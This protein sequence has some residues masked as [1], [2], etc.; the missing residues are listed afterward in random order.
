M[1]FVFC[2]S[3]YRTIYKF[4]L[5]FL[6]TNTNIL[7]LQT[8]QERWQ[9]YLNF[10]RFLNQ[11]L[12]NWT[13]FS[14][15]WPPPSEAADGPGSAA[16]WCSWWIIKE[17]KNVIKSCRC[18]NTYAKYRKNWSVI[19]CNHHFLKHPGVWNVFST[20]LVGTNFY[21]FIVGSKKIR[22]LSF[23]NVLNQGLQVKH[24]ESLL[25]KKK[26]RLV[27]PTIHHI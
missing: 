14:P 11:Q 6:P 8:W 23:S 20:W 13:I 24:H 26:T 12:I 18:Q 19:T 5:T 3:R 21:W 22:N 15:I 25:Q 1:L 9:W 7:C 16:R 2:G 17:V 4:Y 27:E 10:G